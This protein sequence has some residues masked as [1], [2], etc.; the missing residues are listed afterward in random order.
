MFLLCCL[1]EGTLTHHG[2]ILD[3]DAEQREM[4]RMTTEFLALAPG[5]MVI[6][7]IEVRTPGRWLRL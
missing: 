2:G 1:E 3:I 5:W 4:A 6:L 7:V